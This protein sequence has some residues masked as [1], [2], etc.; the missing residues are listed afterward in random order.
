[1]KMVLTLRGISSMVVLQETADS[2][3]DIKLS[4]FRGEN[5]L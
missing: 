2:G 4:S 3:V 1:M 5:R